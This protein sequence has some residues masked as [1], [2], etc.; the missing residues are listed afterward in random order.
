MTLHVGCNLGTPAFCSC[1]KQGVWQLGLLHALHETLLY[2]GGASPWISCPCR[3][4]R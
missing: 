4:H 1:C 3:G 2:A